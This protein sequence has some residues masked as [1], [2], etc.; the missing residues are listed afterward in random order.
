MDSEDGSENTEQAIS[1]KERTQ[2]FNKLASFDNELS[3]Q[4]QKEKKIKPVSTKI[5]Y[6]C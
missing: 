5:L 4:P 3:P 1:V 6:Y 2:K